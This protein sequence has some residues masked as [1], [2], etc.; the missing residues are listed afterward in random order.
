MANKGGGGGECELKSSIF[1]NPK[2]YKRTLILN[3]E[4]YLIMH[5]LQF[6]LF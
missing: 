2:L 3:N 4:M 6:E 1:L 5:V